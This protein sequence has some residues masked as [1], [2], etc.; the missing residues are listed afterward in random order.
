MKIPIPVIAVVADVVSNRFTHSRI[1]NFADA[2]GIINNYGDFA[3]NKLE[4]VRF[5]M[6]CAND[7]PEPLAKLGIF[8]VELMEVDYEGFRQEEAQASLEKDRGRVRESLAKHGLTYLKDG[9][10]VVTGVQAVSKTVETFI[11]TRD[12]SGVH[13]EF[14]R[15]SANVEADPPAAVTASCALLESLFKAYTSEEKLEMPSDKS[16]GPLWKVVRTHLMLEPDKLQEDDIR[17]VLT[18]LGA[19]VDGIGALRTH[20]GSAHGREKRSYKIKPHHARLASHAAFTIAAFIMERW[21][22]R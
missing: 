14:D 22:D 17:K 16:L 6:K 15:I 8:I 18:R 7:D 12:L 21:S 2:A 11:K 1:A 20:E 13:A 9:K 10:I 19:I 4:V 3:G 5:W